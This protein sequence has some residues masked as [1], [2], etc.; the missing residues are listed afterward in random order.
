V[1]WLAVEIVRGLEGLD[2]VNSQFASGKKM[3]ADDEMCNDGAM[4]QPTYISTYP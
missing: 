2:R 1:S 3:N 4:T